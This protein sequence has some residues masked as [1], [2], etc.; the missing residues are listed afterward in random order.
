M[1]I[2]VWLARCVGFCESGLPAQPA[3]MLPRHAKVV[4]AGR[5]IV[6][7]SCR[8]TDGEF[9]LVDLRLRLGIS[10]LIARTSVSVISPRTPRLFGNMLSMVVVGIKI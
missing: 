7:R 3:R 9:L 4:K 8:T 5:R 6:S 1:A 10:T 2:G